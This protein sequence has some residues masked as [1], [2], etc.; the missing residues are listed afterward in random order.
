MSVFS[1]YEDLVPA[2]K[3][4]NL[5]QLTSAAVTC[6]PLVQQQFVVKKISSR[7]VNFSLLP[8]HTMEL[9]ARTW[10]VISGSFVV[11]LLLPSPPSLLA[12]SIF[13]FLSPPKI[14]FSPIFCTLYTDCVVTEDDN[15]YSRL[16]HIDSVFLL[17]F[18]SGKQVRV[19]GYL[20]SLSL[21]TP[22][23]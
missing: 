14:S 3:S 11:A 6:Q 9:L 20:P 23:R 15:G 16:G 19:I 2:L 17:A 8:N 1:T 7:L 21:L 18:A 22:F 5:R 13:T 12:I 4:M 10:S